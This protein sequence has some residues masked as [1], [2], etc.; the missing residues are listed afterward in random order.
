VTRDYP[1]VQAAVFVVAAM[2]VLVNLV[3]D[4]RVRT[5]TLLRGRRKAVAKS[6]DDREFE[7]AK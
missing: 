1:L 6:C 5:T 7:P 3:V 4:A 2:F